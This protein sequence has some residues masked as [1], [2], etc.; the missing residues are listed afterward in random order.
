MTSRTSLFNR[1]MRQGGLSLVE[2]MVGIAVGL[3]V[4]AGAALLVS[5]QLGENRRLL[6]ETQ[7]QQD[8]RA[9][10]DIMSR[11]LRRMGAQ[12]EPVALLGLAS[13]DGAQENSMARLSRTVADETVH[14]LEF[15]YQPTLGNDDFGFKLDGGV[16]KSKLGAS[17]W[18][19][20]TDQ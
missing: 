18:Q 5:S 9:A 1:R 6:L 8:M 3:I 4:V 19:E 13:P 16:V 15:H 14:S 11:E 20:L 17:G 7:L 10:M 2:M 12:R